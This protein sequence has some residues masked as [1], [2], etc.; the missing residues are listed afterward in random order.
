MVNLNFYGR[1][2][3]KLNCSNNL[4][5]KI[6]GNE[7]ILNI[8]ISSNPIKKFMLYANDYGLV[9]I[10]NTLIK[11]ID[12]DDCEQF[13]NIMKFKFS[14]NLKNKVLYLKKSDYKYRLVS[15]SVKLIN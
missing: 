1:E 3:S 13:I 11:N 12:F 5:E 15:N 14:K 6:T 2:I 7:N 10:R 9:D 8:N 4:L